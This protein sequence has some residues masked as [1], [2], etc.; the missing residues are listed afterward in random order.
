MYV[1][2]YPEIFN[3]NPQKHVSKKNY[4]PNDLR[5]RDD[6]KVM[7]AKTRNTMPVLIRKSAK[8]APNIACYP[9]CCHHS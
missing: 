1:L 4:L 7:P 9:H 3:I 8:L 2:I 5:W 6:P